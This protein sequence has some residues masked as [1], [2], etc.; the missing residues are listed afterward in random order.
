MAVRR[1]L[2]APEEPQTF[3]QRFYAFFTTEMLIGIICGLIGLINISMAYVVGP[4]RLAG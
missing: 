4:A 1:L 2:M 3:R